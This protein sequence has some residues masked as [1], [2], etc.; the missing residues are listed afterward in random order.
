MK[1]NLF[2]FIVI[3][4][5]FLS[6]DLLH[7]QKLITYPEIPGR[8]PSDKY[9]CRVRQIGTEEWKDAFVLQTI[10]KPEVKDANGANGTGYKSILLNWT[11]SWIAFEFSETAVEVEISKFDGTA[12]K[13]AMVRPVGHA[14]EAKIENGKAYITFDKPAN[15]NVDIDGQMEDRYTGMGYSGPPVHTIS[16]F[17]NPVFKEPD[18]SNSKVYGLNPGETIP[19]DRSTWDTIYFKPGVHHIGTPFQISSNKVLYIPGN[20]V[21]HGTI[22]P[23]NTWGSSAAANWS[24]YGSGALSG[25]EVARAPGEKW[26]K[27]FTYQANRV[28]LEGFV[29][30]DPAHHTFN[31]NNSD[32]NPANVNVYKNLKILGWRVNGDGLNAFRNSEIT[33]C[34]FRCQDDHFYYGGDNVRISNSVCWSDFNGAVLYVTKGAKSMESSYFKDIKVIYHRAGWHY[35]EGGR[36]ISFRDRRP[37]HT[38]KNVQIK[39]VLVEDPFPAFP[40]FYFKMSNPDNSSASVDY[41]NI[42]IENVV[43]GHPGVSGSGDNNYGKP[44][45]TMLGLDDARK[46]TN[47][48]FK[49]CSYNNKW[50]GSFEDGNFLVNKYVENI[51]FILDSVKHQISLSV[52]NETGGTVSGD[53]FYTHGEKATIYATPNAN[54]RFVGWTINNDTVSAN[55]QFTFNVTEDKQLKANFVLLTNTDQ[56]FENTFKFYPNPANDMLYFNCTRQNIDRFQLMDANG[57]VVY[58]NDEI[59]QNKPI[60]LSVYSCGLYFV[61]VYSAKKVYTAKIIISRN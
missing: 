39:N 11:A 20:A 45:N 32:E 57:K 6:S 46:F 40:P 33:D 10:S 47:I 18:L 34:F 23:P 15:V 8:A 55:T 19:A 36:V 16:L 54:Y 49:N 5:L 44:R 38:I 61:Q 43:Q 41:D 53:G 24:V 13:K 58:T 1:S 9:V 7:A 26:N 14:S 56:D 35:W 29:V 51:S 37:G 27:P 59:T 48:T 42:I 50:L 28:R 25:E 17:A 31:M 52:N 21:V 12:I 30:V 2:F 60:D 4:T 22:H 3:Q